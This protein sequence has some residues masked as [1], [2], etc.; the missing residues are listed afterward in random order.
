MALGPLCHACLLATADE[1]GGAHAAPFNL[2]VATHEA[3]PVK[4]PTVPTPTANTK[5][6]N[7]ANCRSSF[8][9]LLKVVQ[10]SRDCPAKLDRAEHVVT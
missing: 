8:H 4:P 10:T 7:R 2:V 6:W 9:Q 3:P 1:F 5:W